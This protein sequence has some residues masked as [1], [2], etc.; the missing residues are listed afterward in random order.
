MGTNHMS[1]AEVRA[2][3]V[4]MLLV[5]VVTTVVQLTDTSELVGWLAIVTAASV[6]ALVFALAV[7]SE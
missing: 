7:T 5:G 6:G 1:R 4:A 2:G 3:A